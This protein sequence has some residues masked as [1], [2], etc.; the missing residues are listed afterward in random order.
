[1]PEKIKRKISEANKGKMIGDKNPMFGKT[2]TESTKA[3]IS[4]THTGVIFTEERREKISKGKQGKNNPMFGKQGEKAGNAKL[5]NL[6]A[7]EIRKL[8]AEKTHTAR[9]LATL[10]N[11]DITCIYDIIN[12]YSY[13]H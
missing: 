1:M 12:G 6:Q 4:R 3:I 8:F 10:Y 13:N 11:I 5:T 9:Q 7:A 2:H